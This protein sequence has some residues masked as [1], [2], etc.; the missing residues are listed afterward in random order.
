MSKNFSRKLIEDFKTYWLKRWKEEISV[1]T[2]EIYLN[3]L[4]ELYL[5]IHEI[6]K[7]KY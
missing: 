7:D 2:A 3:S 6:E 5:C 4:A 1:D